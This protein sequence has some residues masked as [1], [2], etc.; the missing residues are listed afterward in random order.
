MTTLLNEIKEPRVIKKC[1]IDEVKKLCNEIR[2]FLID[3]VS[4]TGGHIG[5]NLGVVELTTA[6]HYCFDPPKDKIIFDTGHQGYTHKLLTGR[7]GLFS[8]L[9]KEGGMSRFLV[10][11][12]SPY[13]VIDASHG[14]TAISIASGMAYK[15]KVENKDGIVVSIVGDG[16]L[17]EGMSAEGLNY[18][19]EESLPLVI[20]VNDNGMAIPPNVGGINNMFSSNSWME[21][22]RGYFEALGFHYVPVENGHDIDSLVTAFT[23]AKTLLKEKTVVVHVKT[24]KGRGLEIAK[25]HKYKLHFSMPFNPKTGEGISPVPTGAQKLYAQVAADALVDVLR[26]NKNTYV[27]TPSTP[28]ASALDECLA[29]FPNQTIDV[30][31]A[32]QQALGMACGLSLNGSH[33]FVCY[34]STFM[35]RAMDQIL[36]DASFMKLPVTILAVRSGFAGLDNDTHHGIYDFSYLRGLSDIEIFYP[37]NSAD[38]DAIIRNRGEK[39]P[40]GPMIVLYPYES[41]SKDDEER[42][43]KP[44]NLNKG[45]LLVDGKD[46][47]F[48]SV[49]NT[50]DN[51]FDARKVLLEKSIDFGILNIRWIKPLPEKQLENLLSRFSRIL[52]TEE[53]VAE[54]GFGSS[55]LEFI[56]ERNLNCEV[57]RNAIRVPFVKAGN[58]DTLCRLTGIDSKSIVNQV[59]EKWGNQI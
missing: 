17:V 42:I 47:L 35:Q 23:D 36:H 57:V 6:L 22:S 26:D 56:C 32:E 10:R 27:I 1:S 2:A 4:K 29:R 44:I 34:Q 19:V 46:G 52:T 15:N 45:Q 41:I 50:L 54:A 37:G 51:V 12:E 55:I 8:S 20:I 58:K 38:L 59:L 13:D 7:I 3:S 49:G 30:G 11:S 43:E 28:Y 48:I 24:E 14:G 5:T 40:E 18:S 16:A 21:K 31:M 25:D 33:V 9:N 39:V 53:N